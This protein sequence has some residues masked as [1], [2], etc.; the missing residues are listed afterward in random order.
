MLEIKV[1]IDA[2]GLSAAIDNLAQAISGL[3]FESDV[4]ESGT[5][6]TPGVIPFP[7]PVPDQVPG[8]APAA[9]V[10]E[11]APATQTAAAPAP[12]P[13]P[14]PAP[15]P[16]TE[17]DLN[18]LSVAGAGLISQSPDNMKKIMDLLAAYGV[19]AI[20]QLDKS[21]YPAFADELRKLGASI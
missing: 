8:S 5:T 20:T 10:V 7:S 1:T 6:E 4:P 18:A 3:T 9:P 15:Q 16:Q 13:Q 19:K 21:Q 11:Q 17:I 14:I 12:A 2:P